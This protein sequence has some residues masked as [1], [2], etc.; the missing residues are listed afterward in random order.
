MDFGTG[1]FC[2]M[3]WVKL[4]STGSQVIIDRGNE[5]GATD[6]NR[7]VL[8]HLSGS[9]FQ[10]FIKG[11]TGETQNLTVGSNAATNVW[12]H[13]CGIRT[14]GSL[15]IYVNGALA[16]S[17]ASTARTVTNASAVTRVGLSFNDTS[18][19]GGSLALVR[20]SAT[21][22]TATQIAKIY[23][24]ELPLFQANARA[25]LYGASDAV[26][27]LAHDPD[28]GLLHVGTSAGRSVFRGLERLSNTTTSV[29][30]TISASGGL[31]VSK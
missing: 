8:L 6:T 15:F 22:P 4:A 25:T 23:A 9:G 27:A 5:D 19:F 20:I 7:F 30:A 18:A 17:G 10:F 16:N 1:D 26:T 28:T 3:G 29:A 13:V 21:A 2:V 12:Q 14:G 31:I 11:G 24:D